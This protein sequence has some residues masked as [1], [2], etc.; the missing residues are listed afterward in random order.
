V[1]HEILG[2]VLLAVHNTHTLGQW[3]GEC[4]RVIK[5]GRWTQYRDW[6]CRANGLQ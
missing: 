3:M 5:E 1:C 6:F 4:R 2:S